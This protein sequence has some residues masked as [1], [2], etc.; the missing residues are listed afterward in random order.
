M[1]TLSNEERKLPEQ[2]TAVYSATITDENGAAVPLASI[3]AITLTL[4]NAADGTT[5]NSRS[6]QNILNTNNVTI[7]ATSG[8][9]TWTM[10]PAD[11]VIVDSS[12]GVGKYERHN[13]LIEWTYGTTKKGKHLGYVLVEQLQKVS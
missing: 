11:N 4:Y 8:L 5:I 3:N 13:F 2:T 6:A 10:Q 12:I 7:H 1:T 9:L